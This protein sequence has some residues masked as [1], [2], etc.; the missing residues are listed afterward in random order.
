MTGSDSG[1]DMGV[2]RE[3]DIEASNSKGVRASAPHSANSATSPS[4]AFNFSFWHFLSHLTGSAID[5]DRE[6][7][8][9]KANC[10]NIHSSNEGSAKGAD[11]L[12][13]ADA[14]ILMETEADILMDTLDSDSTGTTSSGSGTGSLTLSSG[15]RARDLS[16]IG[17]GPFCAETDAMIAEKAMVESFM[18]EESVA[19][20]R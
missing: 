1:S 12:M 19:V 11:I 10:S 8:E 5:I 2:E 15:L 17:A 7:D 18:V 6:T 20:S 3:K 14:D 4:S 16:L 13:E 9:S